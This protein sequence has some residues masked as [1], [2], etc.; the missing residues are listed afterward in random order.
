MTADLLEGRIAELEQR[1]SRFKLATTGME[2][3]E[4][5]FQ[6]LIMQERDY[7]LDLMAETIAHLQ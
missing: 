5:Y 3:W 4:N 2:D 7:F 6:S 1:Q